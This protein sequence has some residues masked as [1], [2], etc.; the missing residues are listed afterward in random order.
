MSGTICMESLCLITHFL[1]TSKSE[2]LRLMAFS[3]IKVHV[4]SLFFECPLIHIDGFV[5][6]CSN[7]IAN[8]LEILQSCTKPSIWWY[9][10][11]VTPVWF[12]SVLFRTLRSSKNGR[13]FDKH[14]F[15]RIYPQLK[16]VNIDSN[17]TDVCS[18]W[19]NQ[20]LA[21]IGNIVFSHV[22]C[23]DNH[24]LKDSHVDIYTQLCTLLP[25]NMCVYLPNPLVNAETLQSLKGPQNSEDI[26]VH[27][28]PLA[29]LA[30][31][32]LKYTFQWTEWLSEIHLLYL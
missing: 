32:E 30:L 8:A 17:V 22:A 9:G 3:N 29:I 11:E 15:T 1:Q 28:K 24:N 6:D 27:I 18:Q 5:H 26:V 25:L 10:N 12:I 2:W 16:S 23:S 4:M 14:H 19:F 31:N 13:H 7:S 20:Q 21:S